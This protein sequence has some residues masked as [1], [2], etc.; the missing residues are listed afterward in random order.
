MQRKR[1]SFAHGLY[2]LNSNK[3]KI[4]SIDSKTKSNN[5]PTAIWEC[6]NSVA[7]ELFCLLDMSIPTRT[8]APIFY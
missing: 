7:D 6:V 4:T 1:K 3:K 2:K 5:D 8:A